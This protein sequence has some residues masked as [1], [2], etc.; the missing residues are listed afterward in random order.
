M[1][2]P[3]NDEGESLSGK[4]GRLLKDHPSFDATL[5]SLS[6][7]DFHQLNEKA[8]HIISMLCHLRASRL[9][10]LG[11]MKNVENPQ[12]IKNYQR[13]LFQET[14]RRIINSLKVWRGFWVRF[15]LAG[16]NIPF[17]NFILE[18]LLVPK[19]SESGMHVVNFQS[20][21]KEKSF[22]V[23]VLQ[24]SMEIQDSFVQ[25]VDRWF[26]RLPD[27]GD[28]PVLSPG[29]DNYPNKPDYFVPGA[30]DGSWEEVF[31]D[32][33]SGF[34]GGSPGSG[35]GGGSGGGGGALP[36]IPI[37]IDKGIGRWF[38]DFISDFIRGLDYIT[39]G[40]WTIG[41]INAPYDGSPIS[42]GG[43]R[44]ETDLGKEL[45]STATSVAQAGVEGVKQ[46]L[47]EG[48]AAKVKAGTGLVIGACLV[49]GAVEVGET[50][51]EAL[52]AAYW[53]LFGG[54]GFVD[55]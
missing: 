22:I 13:I 50:I 9:N 52:G 17:T 51:G 55:P 19:P 42:R 18:N 24:E 27:T 8:V 14:S 2:G 53:A 33:P 10:A 25:L 20:F 32:P 30:H 49:A 39:V 21:K 43:N 4:F 31:L 26:D 36:G 5:L 28:I 45:V 12:G 11:Q 35:F 15:E 29:D 6:S 7:D 16:L 48:S 37:P 34:G 46:G 1:P 40:E 3:T 54:S 38:M 41:D 47:G 23:K 44:A